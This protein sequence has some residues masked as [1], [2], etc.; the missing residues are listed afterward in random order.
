MEQVDRE[1]LKEHFN[2]RAE[3]EDA[4][5]MFIF[6]N[7][8]IVLNESIKDNYNLIPK[9]ICLER[10]VNEPI[11]LKYMDGVSI[12]PTYGIEYLFEPETVTSKLGPILDEYYDL[13]FLK[14]FKELL[15]KYG[16]NVPIVSIRT[17][18]ELNEQN[19]YYDHVRF[20]W[21]NSFKSK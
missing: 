3:V 17:G 14:R 11:S 1:Y 21:T 7:V 5:R 15:H 8:S 16:Y 2:E 19:E 20:P 4:F 13:N 10:Q 12:L 9:G 18:H 6:E